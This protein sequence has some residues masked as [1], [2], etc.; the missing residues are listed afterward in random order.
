MGRRVLVIERSPLARNIYLMILSKLDE[1]EML[2]EE[3]GESM[4]KIQEIVK[5]FDLIVISQSTLGDRKNDFLKLIKA[6]S[7]NQKIPCILFVNKGVVS[8]WHDFSVLD[9]VEIIERPFRP[10]DML[11]TIKKMWG[12]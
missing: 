10:D 6:I 11:K 4:K 8:E 3:P 5:G 1:V 7:K 12:G 2:S 9:N